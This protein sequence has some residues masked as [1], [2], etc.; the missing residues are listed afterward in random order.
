MMIGDFNLS[1]II[2]FHSTISRHG[3]VQASLTLLIWLNEIV[4][5]TSFIRVAMLLPS[6]ALDFPTAKVFHARLAA[7]VFMQHL[8]KS[9][10]QSKLF[11]RISPTPARN[12][13]I[14]DC[15]A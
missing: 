1:T 4:L 6:G 11:E 7:S 13:P 15:R 14:A 10:S 12:L 9:S 8:W 2:E 3:I 5:H